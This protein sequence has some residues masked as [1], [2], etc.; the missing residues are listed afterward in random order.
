M[1]VSIPTG[2]AF[3]PWDNRDSYQ[4]FNNEKDLQDAVEKGTKGLR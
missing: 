4:A 3:L 1:S 2:M